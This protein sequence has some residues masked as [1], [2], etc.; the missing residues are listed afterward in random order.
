MRK[1]KFSEERDRVG[2]AGRSSSGCRS[3]RSA[4]RSGIS[5]NTFYVWKRRFG[6]MEPSENPPAEAARG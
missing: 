4:A 3:R 5:S 2:G 1:S 6:S